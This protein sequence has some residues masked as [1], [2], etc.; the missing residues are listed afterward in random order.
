MIDEMPMQQVAD[1][2]KFSIGA[3]YIARSRVI[4]DCAKSSNNWSPKMHSTDQ[5]LRSLLCDD[6]GSQ[7]LEPIAKH[8]ETCAALPKNDWAN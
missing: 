6:E 2:L 8:V 4:A 5:Q 1:E 7:E 3:V